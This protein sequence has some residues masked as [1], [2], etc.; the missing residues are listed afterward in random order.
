VARASRLG[1]Q[2]LRLLEIKYVFIFSTYEFGDAVSSL[3]CNFS[4]VRMVSE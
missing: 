3:K 4:C 1:D 2:N